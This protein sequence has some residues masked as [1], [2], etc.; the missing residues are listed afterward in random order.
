[1]KINFH[2]KSVLVT[3]GTKGIGKSIAEAFFDSGAASINITGRSD[4]PPNWIS[5]VDFGGKIKYNQIDFSAN[6]WEIKFNE[7]MD[8]SGGFDCCVN[9]AGINFVHDITGFPQ[10]EMKEIIRVNLEAPLVA[11]GLV[12]KKMKERGYGRIVNIASIF[13]VVSKEKR[14]VYTATK[15]GLIGATKTM[16]LD[17][18]DANV[19]VN[20]VS[21][22]FIE[23]SLT[24]RVLG[25][26]GMIEMSK[27]IPLR[28]LG[29]PEEVAKAVLFLCSSE[30]TYI[31]GHNLVIDGGFVCA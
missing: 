14:S 2:E 25:D 19:L 21:P 7:M 4:S 8:C 16:A 24:R 28:R 12:A 1:M 31:T 27:K 29:Q 3:G 9:N 15:S 5:S 17:F 20:A 11:T 26:D 22:G 13:G 23:T 10:Q 18:L 30:N 6:N